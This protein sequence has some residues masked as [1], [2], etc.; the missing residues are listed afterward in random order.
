MKVGDTNT[1]SGHRGE[2]R[3]TQ[4]YVELS[5]RYG[6]NTLLSMNKSKKPVPA[7]KTD[8]Y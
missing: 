1:G 7:K 8:K 5:S 6:M 4:A 3:L 2:S